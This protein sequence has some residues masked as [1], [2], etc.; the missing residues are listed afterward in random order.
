MQVL[1]HCLDC[2]RISGSTFSTNLMVDAAGF[3]LLQGTPKAFAK[4]ADS[5]TTITSYFCGDCGSTLWRETASSRGGA[6]TNKTKII[7]AGTLDGTGTLDEV[8]PAVELFTKNRVSWVP[9]V[10]GTELRETA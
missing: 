7:K 1:C 4:T 9:A 3:T 10:S 5:G 6:D 2:R 8:R